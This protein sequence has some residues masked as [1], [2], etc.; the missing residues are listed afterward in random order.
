MARPKYNLWYSG[1]HKNN[2]PLG[3]TRS[4]IFLLSHW[5]TGSIPSSSG[6]GWYSSDDPN[7]WRIPKHHEPNPTFSECDRKAIELGSTELK[8]VNWPITI[9]PTHCCR[10]GP[11]FTVELELTHI[12]KLGEIF[13][14]IG[15]SS[16]NKHIIVLP[17]VSIRHGS[18]ILEEVRKAFR[19]S[20]AVLGIQNC[21]SP[22]SSFGIPITQ[23]IHTCHIEAFDC[24]SP[25]RKSNVQKNN[26]SLLQTISWACAIPWVSHGEMTHLKGGIRF[27]HCRMEKEDR[28]ISC[29]E[30][31]LRINGHVRIYC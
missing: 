9:K 22:I 26:E 20:Y 15:R 13:A 2:F 7:I 14:S 12:S 27:T 3:G 10:P 23:Q 28:N 31:I 5:A 17:T 24:L 8:G 25:A 11:E 29:G 18:Y 16:T 6:R 21:I 1:L 30:K 4:K 19:Y